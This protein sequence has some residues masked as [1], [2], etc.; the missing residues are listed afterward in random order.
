[1]EWSIGKKLEKKCI[2]TH[3][4]TAEKNDWK[5]FKKNSCR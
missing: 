4:V 1:M 3:H 2:M 5:K